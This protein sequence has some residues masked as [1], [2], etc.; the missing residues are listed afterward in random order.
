[1]TGLPDIEMKVQSF[2]LP[3]L[4]IEEVQ[5]HNGHVY[6]VGGAVRDILLER[7]VSF[8][9][10][11]YMITGI[12]IENLCNILREFGKVD[13]VGKSFGVIKFTFSNDVENKTVD[14]SLPRKEISTGEGHKDFSVRFDTD[15]PVEEDLRRR[16][17]T[18]NAMA[19]EVESE[20]L[21]VTSKKIIDPFS[22]KDDINDRLIRLMNPSA[23]EEDPLRML[24]AVQ[25]AGRFEFAIEEETFKEMKRNAHR[26]Q[27][28]SPERIQEEINKLLLKAEK[29]SIGFFLMQRSGLL[30]EILPELEEGVGIDQPGGYHRYDVFKHSILTVDEAPKD[31]V[32]R[33]SALFHD[34]AKPRTREIYE[35]GVTFYG[36]DKLGADMTKN[37]LIRLRY[38]NETINRVVLLVDKHMFMP[39]ETEKGLR[40][41]LRKVGEDGIFQLME[42]RKADVVAQGMGGSTDYIEQFEK[43]VKEE[44]SKKPPLSVRDLDVDGNELMEE[45]RLSPGPIIGKILNHL[46]EHVIANPLENQ[47]DILLRKARE[48]LYLY[49]VLPDSPK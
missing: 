7:E 47:K 24:R 48:Y 45:F 18:I 14:I 49:K 34:V 4:L 39:P 23:F 25:F 33:L 42:L 5:R 28:V 6:L 19:I 43:I 32:L 10:M 41:L 1:M 46:L 21:K 22:G 9:D 2:C 29:P 30:K 36:H 13:L 31:L 17:F 27:S 40:R 11:D 3:P 44:L 35:G 15:I 20:K 12:P 8:K 26:I 38:P 37:A 16:D